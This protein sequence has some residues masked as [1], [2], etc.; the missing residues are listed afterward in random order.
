VLSAAR[1]YT[2]RSKVD[3]V[4]LAYDVTID[5]IAC[6]FFNTSGQGLIRPLVQGDFSQLLCEL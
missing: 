6:I 3:E 1:L 5:T 4:R 2:K